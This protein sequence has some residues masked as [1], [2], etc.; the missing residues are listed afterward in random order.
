VAL[1]VKSDG[2]QSFEPVVRFDAE[3]KQFVAAPIDLGPATDRVF[4]VMFATACAIEARSG[5]SA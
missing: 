5:R 1:R 4:L 2:S 3:K